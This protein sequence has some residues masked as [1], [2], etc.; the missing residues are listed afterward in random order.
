MGFL[1][2][3]HLKAKGFSK[4]IWLFWNDDWYVEVL[5]NNKQFLYVCIYKNGMPLTLF[6]IVY[7]SPTTNVR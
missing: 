4:G 3:H 6:I 1:H 7:S 2:W 5:L